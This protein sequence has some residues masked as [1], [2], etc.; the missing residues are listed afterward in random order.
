M[1]SSVERSEEQAARSTTKGFFEV[2]AKEVSMA[3][4][5][6]GTMK[7]KPSIVYLDKKMPRGQLPG[8]TDGIPL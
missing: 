2:G 4:E 8:C 1:R 3:D 5:E 7:M 6:I